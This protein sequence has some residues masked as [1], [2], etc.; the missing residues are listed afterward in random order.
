MST[1]VDSVDSVDTAAP[2]IEVIRPGLLTTVQDL[3][4]TGLQHLGIVPG[5]VMDPMAHHLANAMVGNSS[6]EATLEFTLIGPEFRFTQACLIALCGAAFRATVNGVPMPLDRPVLV[7]AGAQFKAEASGWGTRACLAVAG[8]LPLPLVMGSRS[9]YLPAGYGGMNGRALRRG[10]QLVLAENASV[11]SADRFKPMFLRLP[12]SR[13]IETS[14]FQSVRWSV[15]TMTL[16][17][18]DPLMLRAMTG[19]HFEWFTPQAQRDVFD[20][21]WSIL[22]ESNRIGFRLSGPQLL[23]DRPGDILSG[24]TSLGT[25]Q[26][27]ANGQPI[28]LMADHQTTGGYARMLEVASADCARLAQLGPGARVRFVKCSLDDALDL[29]RQASRRVRA[30]IDV[31]SR[32]F[33]S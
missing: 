2:L 30:R 8:G 15:P 13:R 7:V 4:R 9:T 17:D 1:A 24:P 16:P 22:P 3:G 33:K 12:A 29:R 20:A 14:G 26:V 18:R 6:N 32:E 21:T 27:P 5:G 23:R 28:V 19:A 25:V 10:D 31:I 11:L